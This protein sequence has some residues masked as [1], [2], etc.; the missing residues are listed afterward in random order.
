MMLRHYDRFMPWY[1]AHVCDRSTGREFD[2]RI[3]EDTKEAAETRLFAFGF[4]IGSI[5][6][7]E[8]L[9]PDPKLANPDS[10]GTDYRGREIPSGTV[11]ARWIAM[12]NRDAGAFDAALEVLWMDAHPGD[13]HFLL[14]NLIPDAFRQDRHFGEQICWQWYCELHQF[15]F[16]LWVDSSKPLNSVNSSIVTAPEFLRDVMIE[17]GYPKRGREVMSIYK[18]TLNG[19]FLRLAAADSDEDGTPPDRQTAN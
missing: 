17:S 9:V 11:K 19:S 8:G 15:R 5:E 4:M 3:C 12:A 14:D 6:L 13:R 7:G 1:H 10:Y 2:L 18:R 16:E